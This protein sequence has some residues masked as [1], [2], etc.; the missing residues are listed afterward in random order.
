MNDVIDGLL[1][2]KQSVPGSI[3]L[4][5]VDV[6]RRV[7]EG[8]VDAFEVIM[9]RYNQR[10]FRIARS[11]LKNDTDAEDA[12]QEAYISAYLNLK[13]FSQT[14][15]FAGWLTKITVN[16]A[17]S[18]K[19]SAGRKSNVEGSAWCEDMIATTNGAT[20]EILPDRLADSRALRQLIEQAIDSLPEE[21]RIVF[22][23]RVIEQL[24]VRETAQALSLEEATV[25]TRQFRAVRRLRKQLHKIYDQQINQAF[26]FAGLRCD[27]IVNKTLSQIRN[28]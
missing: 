18:K 4:C 12:V 14:R 23:M 7:L 20:D 27:R 13:Q 10:L 3:T 24:S 19:R 9:R 1:Q 2:D 26:G 16:Q 17:L 22:I 8:K 21:F 28:F 15:S 6:V 11:I 5:D 25:K